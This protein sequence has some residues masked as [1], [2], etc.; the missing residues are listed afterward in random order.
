MRLACRPGSRIGE[1]AGES[2]VPV[3]PVAFRNSLHPPSV[4][5]VM[6]LLAAWRPDAALCHSGHDANVC[7]IAARLIPK[8]PRLV[9]MRTYQHGL[10]HAWTYNRLFDRTLVPSEEMRGRLLA[11]RRVRAER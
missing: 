4:L 6:R 7:A 8:R 3:Q 1:V 10:P 11:N 2:G 9:R 5:A